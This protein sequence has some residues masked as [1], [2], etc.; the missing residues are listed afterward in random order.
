MTIRSEQRSRRA[1]AALVLAAL[2]AAPPGA[3]RGAT[4]TIVN[5]DG[6]GEGF[7]DPT[8]VAPVGG[9]SGTTLGQQRLIVFQNAANIW[10]SILPSNV[11]IRVQA[12]FNALACD[13]NGAVL[14]S[15]GPVTVIANF[16]GAPLANHWYHIALANRLAGSDLDPTRNDISAQFN[17]SLDNNTCLGTSGWYYGLDHNE[18]SDIDLLAVVLHEIGHGLGFSTLISAST[19]QLLNGKPDAFSHFILD[20]GT[21][22]TWDQM[23]SGQR[24]AS[25]T[26][27]GHVVWGGAAVTNESP[28]FLGPKPIVRVNSP[29]AIAGDLAF[30]TASFGPAL[31]Q[32]D[33]SGGV[34]LVNDGVGTT[35][36]AC[37]AIVNA[38]QVS[39]HIALID[40][41]TCTFVSKAQAAQAAGAIGVVIANNVSGS[42]P[43]MGGDDPGITIPVVSIT[44]QDGTNIKNQLGTGVNMT[45]GV[46][47]NLHA[48]TD[49]ANRVLLYAPNPVESGS[50]ISHWDVSAFPDLLMEPFINPDLTN[51]VDLT[52]YAFQ[53]LGWYTPTTAVGPPGVT[54]LHLASSPNPFARATAIRF[55][56]PGREPVD[57]FVLDL[58]GRQVRRLYRG[59]LEGGAH[60][61]TWDGED[62]AGRRVAAGVYLS[63]L[64]AG[65][66]SRTQRLVLLR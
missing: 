33:V 18:G 16:S 27:T 49:A 40:R 63:Y 29:P 23:T 54:A 13:T 50:S 57:L 43:A 22:L 10:G 62:E 3:A 44:Q 47:P 28:F 58:A 46:D 38:A 35:S 53:D 17:L 11:E 65:A 39:G 14:G 60:T 20:N 32:P 25:A 4:V 42:P 21:G 59:T 55:D 31:S 56:L 66:L 1:A 5:Q 2:L 41:G 30:G 8:P 6:A 36:D 7:N 45:L 51:S 19:G 61:A 26:N 24:A 9:N 15:A 12:Q 52:R 37:S 48:G 34:V 64:K